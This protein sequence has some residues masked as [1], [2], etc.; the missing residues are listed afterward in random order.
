M[1]NV[2]TILAACVATASTVVTAAAARAAPL[3]Y[4]IIGGGPAGFVLL[5]QLTRNPKIKVTLIE[6]GPDGSTDPALNSE[7][8]FSR[9]I[10]MLKDT[11][12]N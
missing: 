6:A 4:V 1:K 2:L 11:N 7:P 3:N 9:I 8:S 10:Q 5:E 12:H